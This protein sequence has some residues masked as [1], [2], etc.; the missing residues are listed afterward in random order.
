MRK[1]LPGVPTIIRL[2]QEINYGALERRTITAARLAPIR[3]GCANENQT[4][5][6]RIN[7]PRMEENLPMTSETGF[8]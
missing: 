3:K 4:L 1:L 2:A 7:A 6:T 5:T 8:G